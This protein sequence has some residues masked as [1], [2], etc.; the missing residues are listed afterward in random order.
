MSTRARDRRDLPAYTIADASSYL[1]VPHR[2]LETWV[3]GYSAVGRRRARPVIVPAG[4]DPRR[5]SFSNL[6][7]AFV[8]ATMR[9]VHEIPLQRVRRAL[10]FVGDR[11]GIDRPLVH[12]RFQTDGVDLFLDH[13]GVLVNASRAGQ[14]SWRQIIGDDLQRIECDE[15][16][17]AARLF[18]ILRLRGTQPRTVVIDP[19]VSFGR[20]CIAGTGIATRV[21]WERYL[22]G[23]GISMLAVDYGVDDDLV[24]DAIRCESHVEAA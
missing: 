22:A 20:P 4:R 10:D 2:T 6:V 16:G 5:L 17:L 23:E 3:A 11:L 7:E 9:R 8:L 18:P 19:T 24:E 13:A 14:S 1:R 15:S 21:V 12:A